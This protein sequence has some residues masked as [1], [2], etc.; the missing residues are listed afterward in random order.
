MPATTRSEE[1]KRQMEEFQ[2]ELRESYQSQIDSLS[3]IMNE[4]G[5]L[6]QKQNEKIAELQTQSSNKSEA[7]IHSPVVTVEAAE[8]STPLKELLRV[9]KGLADSLVQIT[10][11]VLRVL[12]LSC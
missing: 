1:A 2:R 8:S 3:N 7:V 5:L 12:D 10:E 9:L 11:A 6:V 4:E